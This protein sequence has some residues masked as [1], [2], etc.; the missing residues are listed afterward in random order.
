MTGFNRFSVFRRRVAAGALAIFFFAAALDGRAQTTFG[1]ITGNVTDAN[2]AIVAGATIEVTHVRS[3]YRY[4]TRSNEV[5]NFTLP[6]LREG[7]Y[8][9]RATATGF[10]EFAAQN[11]LLA[12]REERRLDIQFQIGPV[13]SRVEVTAGATLIET[14]TARIGD[15]KNAV[16]LK[17][18]PLNTRSLYSFLAL[19]PGVL[20]AGGGQATR[21]F[22][23][24]RVNQSEQSID[25]ITV[26]NGF[27]GTQ[28]SPLVSYVE[29]Y[30]EVRVD[31]ANNSADIGAVGQVTI[32]SKSGGNELHGTVFDYYSTPWFRA[33]NPFAARRGSGVSHQPGGG[34][35][36]PIVI[37]KLYD[38]HNRSFFFFSFETSRGSN[39]LQLLNPTVPLASWRAGDFSNI[40]T[41]IRN[42]FNNDQPFP[43]NRIPDN[44]INPVSKKIQERFYPLPN[45]GDPNALTAQNYREQKS[46]AFDPNT[47][48]TIRLDHR[49]SEASFIFG[50]WTWNRSHSRE[51]ESN[52]PTI[53]QR[54]Q[55]RD[56]RAFN[57]SYTHSLRPNLISESRWGFAWNDNPRHGPLLGKEVVQFLGI[58]GLAD[59][60]PDI[61]GLLDVQFQGLGLT[62][63]TQTPWR[64]PGF[65]NFAQQ[66][67]QHLNWYRGRHSL[68][69]GFAISRVRFE[70]EQAPAALFGD[71]RFSNRYTGHPY[72]DFLLGIPSSSG[73][74][75]PQVAI[76]RLR[77][78]T[79]LFV[80]DDFK[81][82]PRLTLNIGLR[83][84]LHPSYTE[85]NG[86]QSN[87]DIETGKIVVPKGSLSKVSPLLPRNYVDVIEA[88]GARLLKTDRNSFAPRI[89]LAYRPWGNDTVIRAGFGVFYDVV[90]RPESAGGAPFVIN[91]PMFTNPAN[92]PVVIF[93][94]VFPAT[95]AGPTTVGIPTA[96]RPDIQTPYS[97]QYNLTV[98]HQRWNTGFRLSYIGTN[99]RQG[100][101]Q[102]NI[103]Q[104]VPDNRLYVDKP[105][106]F[107]NYPGVNY[108]TNG[109][110]HQYHSM[111]AEVERRFV[112]G[113]S[114]QGSWV[115]A[116]D[117]GDIDRG[118]SPENAYDRERERGVWLDIPTHR[119]TGNFI[120]ELPFGRGKQWL[121]SGRAAHAVFG[122]WEIAGVYSYHS[123]QFMT[124]LWTGPDPT[125]TAFT[126]SRTPATVT[127]RPDQLRDPNLPS[128]QRTTSR[129]F[130]ASAFSAPPTGRYGTAS[131]GAIKGPT[132]NVFHA[133][134]AKYFNFGER[135][136]L[137]LDI[138][139]TN[140]FNH[141]NYSPLEA[142]ALNISQ[143]AQIGVLSDVG[144]TSD[145]DQSG[146]RSFRAGIRIEW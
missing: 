6:Q 16:A 78:A 82:T 47:Y 18:L 100:D 134:L 143:L 118:A 95:V 105:R 44:L 51:Y 80:T 76:S 67:Q 99:T 14:D 29:S 27:D 89:G 19:T 77:W 111:T 112:K 106:R 122:G 58:T 119:V 5:G 133:G 66:W 98:E 101:Y 61:N 97:M 145:L 115:W 32:I 30:E 75:F 33:R 93:P 81:V 94:R 11:I 40:T 54:W 12:S 10:R 141:P 139:S 1:S 74:A 46:R 55:T 88:D 128:S 126:T 48:Y 142:G 124:P 92:N 63:I 113:F 114:Y 70:D 4:T 68:K 15:S 13:E 86:L 62:R 135:L 116:R 123:G 9:L 132:S 59:N 3:N 73:R 50:R 49:F 130:D 87:F 45:F 39:V 31:M 104:P 136:K 2:G 72:A 23:G 8:T 125:G 65:L 102:F 60:L 110:G 38:G 144:D 140:L 17:S 137:R 57:L 108:L 127:I 43:G 146:A 69:S 120:Y 42:P 91:E 37:P 64:H 24:S 41:P 20:G 26:S 138:T 21:R 71:V 22:A 103:N 107:P 7:E 129:W 131:R 56:T 79:D 85:E 90:S 109:A 83:Y 34:V 84:E 36:G 96:I 117:I 52:L 53:G 35:G 25:G 121:N 28:I